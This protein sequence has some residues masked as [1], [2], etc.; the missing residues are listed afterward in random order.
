MARS[1]RLRV[2]QTHGMNSCQQSSGSSYIRIVIISAIVLLPAALVIQELP[3]LYRSSDSSA[4]RETR[5]SNLEGQVTDQE[6]SDNQ[7]LGNVPEEVKNF[8]TTLQTNFST[9]KIFF[10]GRRI[11][12]IEL[13]PEKNVTKEHNVR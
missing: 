4:S 11:A 2:V 12:P 6:K 9:K 7:H 5:D 1:K 8:Q 3:K 13:L 10:E